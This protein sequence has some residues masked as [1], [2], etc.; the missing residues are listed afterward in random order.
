MDNVIELK[1]A[2]KTAIL[3]DVD[4]SHGV[5]WLSTCPEEAK[6]ILTDL[7]AARQFT[8][9]SIIECAWF[10]DG[11]FFCAQP[12]DKVSYVPH[13]SGFLGDSEWRLVRQAA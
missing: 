11:G 9:P 13:N 10:E 3:I 6:E 2:P 4:Y 12:G 8:W 7:E 5:V 1:T